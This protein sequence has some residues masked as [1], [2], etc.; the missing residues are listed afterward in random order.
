[1][2][3][4]KPDG[5]DR[6]IEGTGREGPPSPEHSRP[7]PPAA[8]PRSTDEADRDITLLSGFARLWTG[9]PLIGTLTGGWVAIAA[10]RIVAVGGVDDAVPDEL[11]HRVGQRIDLAGALLTPGLVD[12]HTHPVYAGNRFAELA[13]RSAGASYAEVAAAGGGIVS[14]VRATREASLFSLEGALRKRLADWALSGTTTV[15]AKTGYHLNE[16]GELEAVRL[17]ARARDALRPS[18]TGRTNEAEESATAS[19]TAGSATTVVADA[20][21]TLPSVVVT[22]LGAHALPPEWTAGETAYLA[23]V[24]RWCGPARAAGAEFCD[25]FCDE[26]YFSVQDASQLLEAAR[27]AGLRLRIHADELARTG[28]AQLAARVGATSADHLLCANAEDARALAGAGVVATLA[29][30]T[31]AAMRRRPPA[32]TFLDAGV[33]L[34][35]SSD[36]NPGT[37]GVTDLTVVLAAAVADLGLSVDQALAAATAGG[38]ASLGLT[39][40]GRITPGLRADLVAWEADHEGAFAWAWGVPA[41]RVWVAGRE[42]TGQPRAIAAA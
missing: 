13:A 24:A 41:Q 2:S 32:R 12:A 14:T 15:E 23:E 4:A 19:P 6:K 3:T 18:G 26:G 38:A 9:D 21:R 20:P 16:E 5:G 8:R 17:L 1:M 22:F 39:D 29:P 31:A 10:G 25:V 36:H 30:I 11:A 37:S 40:R 7:G 42:V 33:T 27:A 35:L 28:G 34:A